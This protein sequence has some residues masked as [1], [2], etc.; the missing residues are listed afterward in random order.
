MTNDQQPRNRGKFSLKKFVNKPL[1]S[2]IL[3]SLIVWAVLLLG[4]YMDIRGDIKYIRTQV[5]TLSSL[6]VNYNKKIKELTDNYVMKDEGNEVSIGVSTELERNSVSVYK[7]NDQSLRFSDAILLT[8]SVHL[9]RPAI[10][11]V[12]CYER[13]RDN[14][15]SEAQI[16]IS[17]EAAEFLGFRNYKKEGIFRVSMKKLL[18]E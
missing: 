16:F 13:D 7:G 15:E 6:N 14:D 11:L 4:T 12:V 17:R 9:Y 5:D 2:S 1:P 3:G 8:N 10:K 18:K